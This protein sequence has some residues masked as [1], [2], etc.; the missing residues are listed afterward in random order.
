MSS[1]DS[2][3]RF[4]ASE[5]SKI[6]WAALDLETVP[7]VGLSLNGFDSVEALEKG[8]IPKKVTVEKVR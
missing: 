8:G 4:H 7:V 2:L 5:D 6:Y 1:W 3:I